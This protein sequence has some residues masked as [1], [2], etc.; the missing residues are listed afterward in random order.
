MLKDT[1]NYISLSEAT[2]I[3]AYTQGYLSLRARQGKLKAT[4]IG[5]NW[6]T[7]REWLNDYITKVEKYNQTIA[8]K[9]GV[10]DGR[11]KNVVLSRKSVLYNPPKNLPIGD[12]PARRRS[13]NDQLCK[14]TFSLTPSFDTI[15]PMLA[16]AF[17]ATMIIGL[18]FWGSKSIQYVYVDVKGFTNNLI[19]GSS[20]FNETI[21]G[22][23]SYLNKEID[24]RLEM[25]GSVGASATASVS[26]YSFDVNGKTIIIGLVFDNM[27]SLWNG[28]SQWITWSIASIPDRIL[29]RQ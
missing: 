8:K 23:L 22:G 18:G 24:N 17:I 28:Y 9:G 1:D 4:K 7:T 27:A 16:V 12:L 5:R 15:R 6:A 25:M 20:I 29:N 21:N 13:L 19:M 3:C 2:K 11:S 14:L 26:D 10:G